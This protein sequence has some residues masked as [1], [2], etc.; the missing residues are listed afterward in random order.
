MKIFF[1]LLFF[2]SP[3][4]LADTALTV[5]SMPVENIQTEAEPVSKPPPDEKELA[6]IAE[7]EKTAAIIEGLN[8]QNALKQ[9]TL[10]KS[11]LDSFRGLTDKLKS[12]GNVE[13]NN[14]EYTGWEIQNR[15]FVMMMQTIEGT[16]LKQD[17]LLKA[18]QLELMK[19]Q[20]QISQSG[21]DKVATGEADYQK[22]KDMFNQYWDSRKKY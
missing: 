4:C 11:A 8:L 21:Q 5:E 10:S 9:L 22:S 1:L 2:T 3:I 17:S 13:I 15:A 14:V 18:Y 6:R 7:E 20:S 16:L 12:Q 19:V